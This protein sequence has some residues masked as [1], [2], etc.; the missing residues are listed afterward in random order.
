MEYSSLKSPAWSERRAATGCKSTS[1]LCLLG[2]VVC[3]LGCE[4]S[5]EINTEPAAPIAEQQPAAEEPAASEPPPERIAADKP[6]NSS[7]GTGYLGGVAAGYR[8]ARERIEVLPV[9]QAIQHFWATEGRYPKSHDEFMNKVVAPLQMRL[10]EVE[11]GYELRYD[12]EDHQLYKVPIEDS[13][14]SEVE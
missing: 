3:A 7:P 12:P 2:L 8:S 11:E 9:N 4:P 1:W 10:P 13:A 6:V 5:A 14:G